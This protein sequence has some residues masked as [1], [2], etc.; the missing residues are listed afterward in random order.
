MKD[1]Y[2][3]RERSTDQGTPSDLVTNGFS[4]HALELPWR[5]NQA[6][7]SCVPPGTYLCKWLHSDHFN[8]D[9]YHVLGVP[10]RE[11][12]EIHPANFAGDRLKGFKCELRGC[13]APGESFG[14]LDHQFAI[15][16][17]RAMTRDFETLM[18]GEDFMLHISWKEGC[19][20][21]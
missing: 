10:G 7:F 6:E 12:I 15:L 5:N 9:V 11:A 20:P 21:L 19:E 16:N 1:V 18:A 14:T 4:H 3:E 2:L 17:S 13:C 8:R